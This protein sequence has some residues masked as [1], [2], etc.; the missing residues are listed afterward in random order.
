[1]AYRTQLPPK[2]DALVEHAYALF[3]D[4]PIRELLN[5]CTACCLS[6]DQQRALLSTSVRALDLE[7]VEAYHYAAKGRGMSEDEVR[8][9]LPRTFE[10]VARYGF[11]GIDLERA[12]A[13]LAASD[14]RAWPEPER[15]FVEA[16]LAE[17]VD[18]ALGQWPFEEAHELVELVVFAVESG[19]EPLQVLEQMATHPA[20]RSVLHLTSTIVEGRKAA[21]GRIVGRDRLDAWLF[22]RAESR[23]ALI[24]KLEHCISD[25]ELAEADRVQAEVALATLR[26]DAST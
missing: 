18:D 3:A 21:L 13:P 17:L 14:W 26:A 24:V 10:A 20:P 7:L 19:R 5:G 4:Y 9:F 12:A 25:D 6:P 8:H 15:V 2:L 16:F 23:A 1:M 11:S 22:Q